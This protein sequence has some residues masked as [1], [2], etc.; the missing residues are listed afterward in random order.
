M[1]QVALK[2]EKEKGSYS[3]VK[4]S[5]EFAREIDFDLETKFEEDMKNTENVRKLKRIAKETGKK[6]ICTAWK[7]KP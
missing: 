6:P 7:L 4:E 3:I 1:I 2:N 5:R